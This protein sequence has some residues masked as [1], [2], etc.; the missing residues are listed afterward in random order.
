MR[1]IEQNNTPIQYKTWSIGG[2]VF[3]NWTGVNAPTIYFQNDIPGTYTL[4]RASSFQDSNLNLTLAA[5]ADMT[6]Y[7][8]VAFSNSS[9]ALQSLTLDSTGQ[10]LVLVVRTKST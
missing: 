4:I 7:F 9:L 1:P 3:L 2:N 10:N 6:A 8:K 5:G